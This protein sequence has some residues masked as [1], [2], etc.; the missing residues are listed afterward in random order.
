VSKQTSPFLAITAGEPAGIGPDL[1]VTLAATETNAAN[2]VYVGSPE[3]LQARADHLKQPLT[4]IPFDAAIPERNRH[5][6][7][8]GPYLYYHEVPCH[9]QVIPGQLSTETSHYVLDTLEAAVQLCEAQTT[10]AMVTGPVHKGIIN[11][12]GIPFSGHT[13]WLRQRTDATDVVM[14]LANTYLRVALTTTHI[15]LQQVSQTLTAARLERTLRTVRQ[16]MQRLYQIPQ[17]TIGVCGLNPHAGEGGHLGQEELQII[18]PC[19]SKLRT[20]G[21]KLI[22]PL[23][24]DTAFLP[25]VRKQ[26]DVCLTHYHDQGLPVLKALDFEGSINV[27]LG[28][29]LIRTSVDHGTALSLAGTGKASA[30]SFNHAV[31][32]AARFA[33]NL[34][35]A[36]SETP[37][38]GKPIKETSNL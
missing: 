30:Q 2:L 33:A 32:A 20:E 18:E 6:V 15:P 16:E 11:D 12:A 37:A 24:A 22:G 26:Y 28:L 10:Q 31:Q 14:L 25:E 29:P 3:I 4:L 35:Q 17:P 19:L 5:T 38:Q 13:D 7:K 34:Q 23:P 36:G 8:T 9:A 1:L 27:S 21:F